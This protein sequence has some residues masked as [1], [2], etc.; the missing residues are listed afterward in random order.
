MAAGQNEG[1]KMIPKARHKESHVGKDRLY[2][3]EEIAANS[4]ANPSTV[5]PEPYWKHFNDLCSFFERLPVKPH[6]KAPF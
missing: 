5:I 4:S 3:V 6:E 1:Q 2:E